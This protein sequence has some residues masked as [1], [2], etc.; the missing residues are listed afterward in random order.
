MTRLSLAILLIWF[1][2]ALGLSCIETPLKFQ[3]PGVTLPIGLGIGRLVFRALHWIEQIFILV[4]CVDCLWNRRRQK[5]LVF[6]CIILLC[7]AQQYGL[8]PTMATRTDQI[9]RGAHPP[10]TWHHQT[11]IALECFKLVALISLGVWG[12]KKIESQNT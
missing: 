10:A 1:G 3:A 11:Y 8:Y 9:I 4:I 5:L 2:L 12:L 7:I 6:A